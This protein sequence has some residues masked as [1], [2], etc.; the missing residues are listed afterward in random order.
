MLQAV[1]PPRWPICTQLARFREPKIPRAKK[2]EPG[3]FQ[4][5]NELKAADFA[6]HPFS[7]R[8]FEAPRIGADET[9]ASGGRCLEIIFR[10][11][12]PLCRVTFE[13]DRLKA[14]QGCT[15]EGGVEQLPQ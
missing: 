4:N 10:A 3:D 1:E 6:G 11:C 15:S 14:A 8:K 12:Q 7:L 5:L 9:R 2:V 13:V